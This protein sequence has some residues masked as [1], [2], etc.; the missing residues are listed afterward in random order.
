MDL[1]SVQKSSS[2][3]AAATA[4]DSQD[5]VKLSYMNSNIDN[6]NTKPEDSVTVMKPTGGPHSLSRSEADNSNS[7]QTPPGD[8]S[9]NG[10]GLHDSTSQR[11]V[12]LGF[13]NQP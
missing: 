1:K 8:L 3:F 6:T 7:Q 5:K 12:Q 10:G 13:A 4:G 2:S 9:N 11:T